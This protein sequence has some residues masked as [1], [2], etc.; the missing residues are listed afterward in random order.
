M[1]RLGFRCFH[2]DQKLAIADHGFCSRCIK[3]LAYSPYC[4]HCG[5]L[6]AE[7]SLSCGECL[8]NEPKW[9]RIVQISVYK[10]PLADSLYKRLFFLYLSQLFFQ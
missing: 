5:S 1:N 6:L 8:R 2:C 9:Q 10:K 7:N 4:G 3:L